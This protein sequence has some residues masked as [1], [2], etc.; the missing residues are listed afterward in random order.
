MNTSGQFS[1]A[2]LNDQYFAGVF[3]STNNRSQ[4][5]LTTFSDNVPDEDGKDEPRVGA[6]VGGEGVN[7]FEFFAGPKD[8]DLLRT[9]NPKLE[10]LIDWGWFGII[11][12]PLFLV[13]NYTV[14]ISSR[15]TGAGPSSWLPSPLIRW[16]C[17]R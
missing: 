11:A 1:F 12:K 13:L 6:A 5:E 15:I 16:C 3:L 14:D 4:M 10:Q 17:S 9:V 7:N 2:G 8:M